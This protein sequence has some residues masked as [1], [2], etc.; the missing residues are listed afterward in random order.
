MPCCEVR[1][2]QLGSKLSQHLKECSVH[3]ILHKDL[4]YHPHNIQVAQELSEWE[5]VSRLQFCNEFLDLVENNSNIVKTLLMSIKTHFHVPDYMKKQNCR[6]WAPK[7]PHQ[8]HQH[9]VHSKSDSVMCCFFSWHYW[10]LV[11]W[12][13]RGASFKCEYNVVQSHAGNISVQWVT[14]LSAT[15]AVVPTRWSNC[16]H[17]T[18][19]HASPKDN[20]SGQTHFSV[21]YIT[22]LHACLTLQY[23]ATSSGATS[24]AGYTKH[25]LPILLT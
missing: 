17:N 23:Q 4:H 8:L 19:F 3:R 5:K 13:C 25:I 14:S 6:Y 15:F 2:C 20:A 21:G 24:K 18:N 12:E 7:Y 1:A 9:P 10:S 22:C 16:L 11:L